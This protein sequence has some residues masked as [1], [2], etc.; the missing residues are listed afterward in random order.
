MI[1][2]ISLFILVWFLVANISC[3]KQTTLPVSEFTTVFN[4]SFLE[5]S[6]NSLNTSDYTENARAIQIVGDSLLFVHSRGNNKVISYLLE[7]RGN[8]SS[9]VYYRSYSAENYIGTTAQDANGHG[10]FIREGDLKR[11]WLFNRTEIWEFDLEVSG[12]ISSAVFSDYL[13]LTDYVERGH[14]IFFHPNGTYLY[15]DDRNK[16]MIHQF[17]LTTAWS[18]NG[19]N[20]YTVLDI[21]EKHEAVRAVTFHPDGLDMY[22][23]DTDLQQIQHYKLSQAWQIETAVFYQEKSINLSNP[24]SFTWNCNG[25]RAFI[26]NTDD[27]VIYEFVVGE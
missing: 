14:G 5:D 13:D 18:I 17:T 15:V 1:R 16:E 2:N 4:V 20:A 21:S 19:F 22:L 23:L 10:F 12:D 25:S 26:M 9:A 8:I 3:S 7:E 6:E 24:R 27:G 11:M